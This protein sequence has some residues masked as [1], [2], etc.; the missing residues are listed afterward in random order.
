[1]SIKL[2]K[3]DELTRNSHRYLTDDDHCY[4]LMEYVSGGGYQHSNSN[5]LI[6]N[7]KKPLSRS[8]QYYKQKAIEEITGMLLSS[9]KLYRIWAQKITWVPIPPSHAK[10]D[11][12]YDD[13]LLQVLL[14][15]VP[16]LD[17]DVRELIQQKA[18]VP[19]SHSLSPRPRP[20]ELAANYFV[21]KSLI[22]SIPKKIAIFDDV[23]TDGAHFKAAQQVLKQRFPEAIIGGIFI[24]RSTRDMQYG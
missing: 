10:D 3:I 1:M 18:S 6:F 14:K 5:Q 21:D 13:R 2:K 17:L 4:F 11:P 7:F 9:L 20:N 8:G 23:I 19:A 22:H 16:K 15:L 24:A 12:E